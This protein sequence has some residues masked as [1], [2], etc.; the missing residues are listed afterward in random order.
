MESISSEYANYECSVCME[1]Y[2]TKI[3]NVCDVRNC[4]FLVCSRCITQLFNNIKKGHINV[5]SC[6]LCPVC[7]K[8]FSYNT[9]KKYCKFYDKLFQFMIKYKN[10]ISIKFGIC[11]CLN[12][13]K[14][15][16]KDNCDI[17]DNEQQNFTCVKCN[18]FKLNNIKNCPSCN[19]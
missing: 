18:D 5:A 12:I 13:I 17:H 10:N 14:Y 9:L 6:I 7:K 8:I 4:I 19:V 15:D 3:Y 16:N 11:E 1:L 2:Y